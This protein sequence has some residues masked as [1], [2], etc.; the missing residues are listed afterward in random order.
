MDHVRERTSL[1]AGL[2]VG[3]A[4]ICALGLF[5]VVMY[6]LT[7]KNSGE[8]AAAPLQLA[9]GTG[10]PF[11][12]TPLPGLPVVRMPNLPPSSVSP[13]SYG[14]TM[15]TYTLALDRATRL[16]QAVGKRHW[17]AVVRVVGPPGSFA[18]ISTDPST[19]LSDSGYACNIVQS[20]QDVPIRLRP[21]D[22]LYARGAIQPGHSAANGVL[23]SFTA[24]EDDD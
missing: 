7:R 11:P 21:R 17:K 14:T 9:G 2:A 16:F 5:G 1:W 6:L 3:M 4:S 15:N 8:V 12:G 22:T 23:V 13:V 19:V 18:F 20:G 10:M 24:Y